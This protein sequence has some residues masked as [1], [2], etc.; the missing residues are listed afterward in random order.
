M[1]FK[2]FLNKWSVEMPWATGD[3][4]RKITVG[5]V[6][7]V[8]VGVQFPCCRWR[9]VCVSPFALPCIRKQPNRAFGT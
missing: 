2:C 7:V 8:G 6:G 3:G 4:G 1:G 5:C 9:W